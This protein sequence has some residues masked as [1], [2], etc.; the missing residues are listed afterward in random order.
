[1]EGSHVA[2]ITH[3]KAVADVIDLAAQKTSAV[4][5]QAR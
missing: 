4:A 1:V 2:F 3:P 5:G